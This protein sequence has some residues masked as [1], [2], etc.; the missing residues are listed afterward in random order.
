MASERLQEGRRLWVWCWFYSVIPFHY[1]I[2]HRRFKRLVSNST[3]WVGAKGL[4]L[5]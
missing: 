1:F 2:P 5:I 3:Y 4:R